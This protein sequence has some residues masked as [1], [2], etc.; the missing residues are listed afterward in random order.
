MNSL[1]TGLMAILGIMFCI[2][3]LC[4]CRKCMKDY[5]HIQELLSNDLPRNNVVN[6]TLTYNNIRNNQ[7][8]PMPVANAVEVYG[9][10]V[11]SHI[12]DI[13]SNIVSL[14]PQVASIDNV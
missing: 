5:K 9:V 12:I 13:N 7:I 14:N 6:N 3:L 4:N 8:Y 11:N 10:P 1:W 2:L